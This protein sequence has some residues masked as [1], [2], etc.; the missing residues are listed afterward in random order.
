VVLCCCCP[1]LITAILAL[2]GRINTADFSYIPW[3][4]LPAVL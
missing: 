2:L 3:S 4:A 1:I